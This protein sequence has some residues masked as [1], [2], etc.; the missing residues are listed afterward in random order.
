MSDEHQGK[1]V[2]IVGGTGA[3]GLA[4]SRRCAEVGYDVLATYNRS[5]GPSIKGVT[6]VQLDVRSKTSFA[7]KLIV[8]GDDE[9]GAYGLIYCAGITV[10][11]PLTRLS[12]EDWETTIAVNLSG[13]FYAAQ[14]VVEQMMLARSGRI[15]FL[16]SVAS[17][18]GVK[19]QANY[20][21]SKAGLEGLCRTFAEELGP[22][23]ITTNVLA[24]GPIDS[25]MLLEAQEARRVQLKKQIPLRRFGTP[26]EVVG[27]V[28]FLLSDCAAYINGQTIVLDGGLY[29][30]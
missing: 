28:M 2:V 18:V 11:A 9:V 4:I 21:A 13:A 15:L 30:A 16:G 25:P 5:I 1:R 29:K 3:L 8:E 23:Q 7:S 17:R 12:A 20:A 22:F 6:W 26:G 27:A 10:D 14:A 19:G 24:T